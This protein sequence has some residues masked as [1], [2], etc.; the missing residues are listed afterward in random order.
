MARSIAEAIGTMIF[1]RTLDTLLKK[2]TPVDDNQAEKVA[3]QVTRDL[4]PIVVNAANA[5]PWYQS[6]IYIGLIAAGIGAIAQHYGVQVS[7]SDIQ[8]ITDSVPE[9]VQAVGTLAEAWGLLYA[10]YGRIVGAFKKPLGQ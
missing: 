9:V 3:A 1:N 8:L 5:E 10:L 2:D 7:G 6:R 4:K